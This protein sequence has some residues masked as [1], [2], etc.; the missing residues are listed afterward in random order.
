MY[1]GQLRAAGIAKESPA[2]TL[3]TPPDTYIAYIPPDSFFPTITLLESTAVRAVP[4]KVAKVTQ[5]PGDLKG[6]KIKFEMEPENIGEHLMAAFGVDTLVDVA[7]FTVTLNINDHIDFDIGGGELNALLT[8]GTYPMGASSAV[9]GS[10]C[11]LI[12]AALESADVGGVYTVTFNGVTKKL[13]IARGAGSYA[14]KWLTG[15]N[16]L[17]SADT[18]LG[19]THADV[20]SAITHT[21]DSTTAAA[22]YQHTFTRLVASQLPQYSWWF[23]KGA[24][25]PQFVGCMLN[26]LDFTIK[27][28]E[29]VQVEADWTGLAYDDTG[30]S[31]SPVYSALK[32]LTFAQATVNIDGAPIQNYDNIKITL[33]NLVKADHVVGSSIYPAKIYSEGFEATVTMDLIVE[34]SVQ[35]AKFLAGTPMVLGVVLTSGEVIKAT[36]YYSLTFDLPVGNYQAAPYPNAPGLLKISFTTRGVYSVSDVKTI[37]AKLV[38]SRSTSY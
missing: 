14:L 11:A 18:L 5:G 24:K 21:S 20:G 32:F 25:F 2:G 19:W 8:P 29:A 30:S 12:K 7:S 23:D 10:L 37:S 9:V 35:Y 38:N 1:T 16:N 26:K 22:V 27:A 3:K 4:D 33:D 6:M 34:D 15:T 28:K 36:K 17:K 13:T 31:K